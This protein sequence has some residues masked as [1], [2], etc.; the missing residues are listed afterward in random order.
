MIRIFFIFILFSALL[1]PAAAVAGGKREEPDGTA[2]SEQQE[3]SPEHGERKEERLRMVETQIASRGITDT[4]VLDALR[5]VPRHLFVPETVR[6]S[7]YQDRPLPIGHGQTISQPY[8]VAFMTEQ[9]DLAAG[10]RVLE[11]GTGSGY[12]A[13]VLAEI[14]DKV[15]TIEIIDEL[16][17]EAREKLERLGY[18]SVKVKAG[19]GYFGW[20]E[21]APFDAV[22]VTAAAG[23][24]PP[25]LL[26]QLKPG[27]I[28]CIPVGPVYQVQTL[29]LVRKDKDGAVTTEQL[30]PVRFVPMTGAVQEE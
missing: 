12:Q 20:K 7:A 5:T 28:I 22:I 10:D 30:L 2:E 29:M 25:P 4:K 27:G 14:V 15:Y 24:L 1:F 21:H 19:D 16:A 11:V 3:S 8:I 17:R 6:S 13:A 26:D 23:H 9:L 18:S